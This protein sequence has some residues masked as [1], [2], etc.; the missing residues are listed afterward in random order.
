M[1]IR[2]RSNK[3]GAY[4][5]M[6]PSVLSRRSWLATVAVGEWPCAQ[7]VAASGPRGPEAVKNRYLLEEPSFG[8]ENARLFD[9]GAG[10]IKDFARPGHCNKH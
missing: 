10:H 7:T 4:S 5:P 3:A 9:L 2:I 1:A 6:W 8:D